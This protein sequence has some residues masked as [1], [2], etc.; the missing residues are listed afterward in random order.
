MT[1][2]CPYCGAAIGDGSPTRI[3]PLRIPQVASAADVRTIDLDQVWGLKPRPSEHR[4]IT[5]CT[6]P[7]CIAAAEKVRPRR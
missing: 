7:A 3:T 4:V 1:H 2:A 6:D 5:T